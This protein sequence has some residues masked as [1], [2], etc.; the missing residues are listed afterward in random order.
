[1]EAETR[2]VGR[3]EALPHAQRSWAERAKANSALHPPFLSFW[4]EFWQIG[5]AFMEDCEQSELQCLGMWLVLARPGRGGQRKNKEI[6]KLN[7]FSS[8]GFQV[9]VSDHSV[10]GFGA[11]RNSW[12]WVIQ[13]KGLE[14]TLVSQQ[15]AEATLKMRPEAR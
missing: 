1:M 8:L 9:H 5:M 7:A 2:E 6:G 4:K 13:R 11:Q 14:N 10:H 12:R 3:S 15:K